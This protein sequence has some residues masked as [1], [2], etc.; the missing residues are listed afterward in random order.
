MSAVLAATWAFPRLFQQNTSV[1][2]QKQVDEHESERN[3]AP[4]SEEKGPFSRSGNLPTVACAGLASVSGLSRPDGS[5][6]KALIAA[7][8]YYGTAAFFGVQTSKKAADFQDGRCSSQGPHVTCSPDSVFVREEQRVPEQAG[9]QMT[10]DW[11]LARIDADTTLLIGAGD[12]HSL[13]YLLRQP[14]AAQLP[15]VEL[16]CVDSDGRC[17]GWA[18]GGECARNADFMRSSC[19]KACAACAPPEDDATPLQLVRRTARVRVS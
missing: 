19:A 17:A 7:A 9:M 8:N 12:G 1:S 13:V 11:E 18:K 10:H 6:S 4:S 5:G 14:G 3:A 15:S 16:P 2:H